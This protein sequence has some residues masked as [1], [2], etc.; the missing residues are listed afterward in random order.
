MLEL[1]LVIG[2]FNHGRIRRLHTGK[3]LAIGRLGDAAL[4]SRGIEVV[5]PVL[6]SG[7]GAR[8]GGAKRD[9]G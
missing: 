4:C 9:G 3:S 7:I 1:R 8:G 6:E 2:L 5:D